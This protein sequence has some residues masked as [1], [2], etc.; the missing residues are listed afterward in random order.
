[1]PLMSQLFNIPKDNRFKTLIA[2]IFYYLLISGTLEVT[3][4]IIVHIND[5]LLLG[6]AS[7]IPT[8]FRY[9]GPKFAIND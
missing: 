4:K 2:K 3:D 9:F 1:M 5:L 6:T 7:Y 8:S